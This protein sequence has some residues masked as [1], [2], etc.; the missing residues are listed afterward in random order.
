MFLFFFLIWN[1]I[2]LKLVL[3]Y[4]LKWFKMFDH[5]RLYN[6]T[7]CSYYF[8]LWRV[9]KLKMSSARKKSVLLLMVYSTGQ[10]L[11]WVAVFINIRRENYFG[12]VSACIFRFSFHVVKHTL[13][14]KT[15]TINL[16]N[17]SIC[18][19]KCLTVTVC[20]SYKKV[21]KIWRQLRQSLTLLITE[22]NQMYTVKH[23]FS[24]CIQCMYLKNDGVLQVL[25]LT[26]TN[27]KY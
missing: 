16:N 7:A 20:S 2:L 24:I 5:W 1:V 15:Y 4:F 3:R 13:D 10:V 18:A 27:G 12:F 11:Y 26:T 6:R 9:A 14:W 17:T 25:A 22:I 23:F 19:L 8:E 21:T